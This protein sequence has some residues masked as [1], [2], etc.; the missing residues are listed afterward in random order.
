MCLLAR[1][2]ENAHLV[3]ECNT[4]EP[5]HL[6]KSVPLVGICA[7]GTGKSQVILLAESRSFK[8]KVWVFS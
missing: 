8:H 4:D 2:I 6:H 7:P 1:M 3:P 5:A